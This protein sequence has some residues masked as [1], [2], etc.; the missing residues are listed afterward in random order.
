[1]WGGGYGASLVAKPSTV[2]APDG[3]A[4]KQKPSNETP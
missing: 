2:A 1:M 3:E 4:V